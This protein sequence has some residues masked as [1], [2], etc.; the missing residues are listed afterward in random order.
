[1]IIH[2]HYASKFQ[3]KI[4]FD[5]PKEQSTWTIKKKRQKRKNSKTIVTKTW[6]KSIGDRKDHKA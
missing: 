5:Q 2:D 3:V 6:I 4:R 1:M